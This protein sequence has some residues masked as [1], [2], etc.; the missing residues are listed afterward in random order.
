MKIVTTKD[1][2]ALSQ[3]AAS[4]LLTEMSQDHRSNISITAGETPKRCYEIVRE[5]LGKLDG[6]LDNNYFYN[7]D[8]V[9]SADESEGMTIRALKQQ[10]FEPLQISEESIVQL[11]YDNYQTFDQMIDHHGG[12]DL[13]L[14][15]LGSDGHFCGNM[16]V[17]T[18]FNQL[19]YRLDFKP[20]YPWHE[21]LKEMYRGGTCP[22]YL[23]TL[24]LQSLL[25]VKHLVL[26]VNGEQ[27]AEAVKRLIEGSEITPD[28]PASGLR[29]HPNLTVILDQP[30]AVLIEQ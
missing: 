1:Y 4:I 3:L 17:A 5:R 29:L 18:D 8:E 11:T 12:L 16:P 22:E 21:G 14:I 19:V 2:E 25:K 30:A 7:F 23:V 6:L 24:G 15:G 9:K 13:M 20:E 10:F 28:F 26:I 27:K